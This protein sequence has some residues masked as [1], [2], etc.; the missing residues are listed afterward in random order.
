M[1]A[2]IRIDGPTVEP[3]T[4]AQ[5]KRHLKE[6]LVDADND[7]DIT[8]L[9]KT[10]REDAEGRLQRTL[11]RTTWRLTLDAFPSAIELLMPRVMDVVSVK[12]IDPSGVQQTLD[13]A[14]YVVDTAS[15]PGFVVPAYG[16]A[17]PSTRR[18]INAV[19]V[20]YRA[21]Y[22]IDAASIPR[23]IVAWVKLA[24][25]DLYKVRGRSAEKPVLPQNF[26]DSLLDPYKIWSA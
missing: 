12:Y 15:E 2:P 5:A 17:W 7:A 10:A 4:L 6:D 9:I 18:Q 22:G 3:L 11:V 19:V 25:A 16:R 20:E 23:P 26:V 21:G 14:D 24:L 8:D 13:P 1:A